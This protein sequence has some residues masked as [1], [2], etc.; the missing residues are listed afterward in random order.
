M[1]YHSA[2]Q[3][4]EVD[5]DSQALPR[6]VVEIPPSSISEME[7]A[8]RI[9]HSNKHKW[10]NLSIDEKILIL[11]EILEDFNEIAED[12]VTVSCHLKGVSSN[13]FAQGEEWFYVAFINRLIRLL[14]RSLV[15]IKQHGHPIIH[16]PVYTRSDGQVVMQVFPQ[17]YLDRI[18]LRGFTG[19]I[20]IEPGITLDEVLKT[21]AAAYQPRKHE[22]KTTLVLGVGNTSFLVVGDFLNKLYVD[23]HVVA[24]KPNPANEYLGPLIEQGFRALI[25]RGFMRLVY[26]GAQEGAYLCNHPLT[27]EIHMTGSHHTFEAIVFG[28]GEDGKQR[29]IARKPILKKYFSAEL[30]N[31]TPLIIVPGDWSETEIREQAVKIASW[32][33]YNSGYACPTPRLI[34][35]SKNWNLRQ[36]I[37]Q[38]IM[39]VFSEVETRNAY[40]PGSR[41]IHQRFILAHPGANQLGDT[42]AGHL[43]WTYITGVDSDNLDDICFRSEAFCSLFA[44]TAIEGDSIPDFLKRAVAFVN[45]NVWGTLNS[46][47]VVHPKTLKNP[48]NAKAF[49]HAIADLRY[50]TVAVNQYPAISYYLG[51]TTWGSFPGQDIYD[52]QSGIGFT[53]N[54]LMIEQPQKSVLRAPFSFS[55]D[56]F[57]IRNTRAEEFG[58]I[59][60]GFE[61]SPS[62]FKVPGILWSV[63]RS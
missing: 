7:D 12:L 4:R 50:G 47:I 3:D 41:E 20:F 10:I 49:E 55:P 51:L 37:N 17:S 57:T 31:I 38:A 14:R 62:I 44:E 13:K 48:S 27:D 18:L 35:Q 19:E 52:I 21:Q 5:V 53:N 32:L 34:I 24:L 40:Y 56:P 58:R 22:G 60:V 46:I 29:K 59:M 6:K 36:A 45:E 42:S 26:G 43:P 2:I 15:E 9:L 25:Q 23:G 54:F 30:G 63:L 11:D 8:L 16:G 61:A 39:D 33:I 28:P 1:S